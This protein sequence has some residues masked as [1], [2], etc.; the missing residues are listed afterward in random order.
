MFLIEEMNVRERDFAA[1]LDHDLIG[2]VDHDFRHFRVPEQ[3]LN[4]AELEQ[5]VY[6]ELGRLALRVLIRVLEGW[7][8]ADVCESAVLQALYAVG[9]LSDE[10]HLILQVVGAS[11]HDLGDGVVVHLIEHVYSSA[12]VSSASTTGAVPESP[13]LCASRASG[14]ESSFGFS[15]SGWAARLMESAV[16]ISESCSGVSSRVTVE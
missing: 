1:A 9:H 16:P 8:A 13:S 2:R 3:L 14:S 10:S 15:L 5:V 6:D 11:R 12:G 7:R 4:G